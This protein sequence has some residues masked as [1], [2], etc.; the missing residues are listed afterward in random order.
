MC[1]SVRLGIEENPAMAL[2]GKEAT[3]AGLRGLA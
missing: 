3:K 2:G 1:S